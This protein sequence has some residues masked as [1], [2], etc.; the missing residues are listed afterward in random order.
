MLVQV[1]ETVDVRK[2]DECLLG[3]D[4]LHQLQAA[5][6]PVP[7]GDE[8]HI[9]LAHTIGGVQG[10]MRTAKDDGGMG[11]TTLEVFA[12]IEGGVHVLRIHREPDEQRVEP[13]DD[14]VDVLGAV[15]FDT[16][17]DDLH[18]VTVETE[19]VG[20]GHQP[21]GRHIVVPCQLPIVAVG[22]DEVH[23]TF[24]KNS[25]YL[26]QRYSRRLPSSCGR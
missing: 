6:L 26:R 3:S 1:D 22:L 11:E 25:S 16:Q 21:Q 14:L 19:D 5:L 9:T 15:V 18:I 24:H 13:L 2:L 12:H 4:G 10:G 20:D 23:D 17:V 7:H 8:V